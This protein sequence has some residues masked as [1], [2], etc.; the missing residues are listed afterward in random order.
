MRNNTLK[1]SAICLIAASLFASCEKFLDLNPLYTQDA[2]NYFETPVDYER[3]L[4]GAYDL[5]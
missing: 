5:L 4:T 3:A 2:E 1:I